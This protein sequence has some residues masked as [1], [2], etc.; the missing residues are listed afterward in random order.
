MYFL[1]RMFNFLENDDKEKKYF[2]KKENISYVCKKE[3]KVFGIL[4]KK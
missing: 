1:K 3:R 2:R 4:F